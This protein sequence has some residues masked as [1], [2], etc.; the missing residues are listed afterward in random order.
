MLSLIKYHLQLSIRVKFKL[1][2]LLVL[3]GRAQPVIPTIT[4]IKAWGPQVILVLYKNNINLLLLLLGAVY[5]S[6]KSKFVSTPQIAR[7]TVTSF[8]LHESR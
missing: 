2:D 7:I 4:N 1:F 3:L 8:K 5:I 6:A